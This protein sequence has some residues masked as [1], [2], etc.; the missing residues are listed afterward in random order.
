M[1]ARAPDPHTGLSARLG[2][3]LQRAWWTRPPTRA[4]RALRPLAALYGA[5]ARLHRRLSRPQQVGVPVL[6]VGN[7]IV[8]G[9]GKTPTTIAVVRLLRAFGWLPGVVSRGHRR[10]GRGVAEVQRDS[11]AS[12]CGDEPL[13]IR[14][15]TGV[16]V[17]VG[18]NRVAA[19]RA[20]R[21]AHPEV[22][23]IVADDG[24][25]H[26]RLA[27][28]LQIIVFD[29]RGAGNGLLLPAGP[30]RE[31]LPGVRPADTLVLYNAAQASTP[32][33]GWLAARRQPGVLPLA[34]WWQG[35]SPAPDSWEAVQGRPLLA[36]AGL[37]APERFFKMLRD[38]GLCLSITCALPDH[39]PFDELPWR[40]DTPDAVIT[41]KDAVK[42]PLERVA[43]GHAATRV[44]VVPLDLEPEM[45]F[46]AA[47]KRHFPHPPKY[48]HQGD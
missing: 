32:L 45:A 3:A 28:D 37:A 11:R 16:P 44:W 30:L 40:D 4:A 9:A 33:A 15:R 20:L 41:E 13:L 6:V 2:A 47:L 1:P 39:D 38:Q 29:E 34:D 25:Q 48:R 42:L 21:A 5:L 35:R 12:D 46:A 36:A 19:A 27:R 26:H 24:L 23:I 31:R 17:M 14:L 18:K 10:H 22:N 7:L 8:G 43:Q